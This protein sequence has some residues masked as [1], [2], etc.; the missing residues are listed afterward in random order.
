MIGLAAFPLERLISLAAGDVASIDATEPI[1]L[2]LS[3]DELVPYSAD[4]LRRNLGRA[5]RVD[6]I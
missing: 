2:S 6:K 3:R 4:R 1:N 5:S